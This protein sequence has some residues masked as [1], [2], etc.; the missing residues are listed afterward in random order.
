MAE[1]GLGIA[2]F[3]LSLVS[4]VLF[5]IWI[6]AYAVSSHWQTDWGENGILLPLLLLLLLALLASGVG[7]AVAFALG[8]A[9]LLQKRRNR[10]F[11]ILGTVFSAS[12]ALSVLTFVVVKLSFW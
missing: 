11:A 8:I 9:A 5:S 2:S 6:A 4:V 12:V 7:S 10:L 1:S 3:T